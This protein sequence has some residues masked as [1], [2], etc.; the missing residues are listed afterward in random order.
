MLV[1]IIP[2]RGGSKR[3]PNKNIKLF[4]GKPIIAYAIEAAVASG[5]F[6]K[7]IVSTDNEEIAKIARQFGA[8]VPFLRSAENSDDFATTSAVL[9]EVIHQLENDNVIVKHVCCLYPTSPLIESI[10]LKNA[11]DKYA[12]QSYDTLISCVAFGFP[13]QRSFQLSSDNLVLLNQ[14]ELINQRS[15]DLPKNYHDAGAMYFFN[16][17]K[18]KNS[19]SL[20]IGTI[21]GYELAELKVQ[22]IDTLEDWEIAELKY[23]ILHQ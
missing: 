4:H 7:V 11:N 23:T 14:P 9:L 21:G 6:S 20:W 13:I 18:F 2:A 1:A 15:Q 3:I 16:V 22:D 10:D 17:A 19:K 12:I 5:I 8:E